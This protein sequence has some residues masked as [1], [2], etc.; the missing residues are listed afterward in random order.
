MAVHRARTAASVATLFLLASLSVSTSARAVDCAS[1]D[2]TDSDPCT[3]DGCDPD[4]GCT[5]TTP[6]QCHGDRCLPGSCNEITGQCPATTNIC[7]SAGVCSTA[8][9][10]GPG[11]SPPCTDT[12]VDCA[13][14]NQCISQNCDTVTGCTGTPIN[15]DDRNVCSDDSCNP[16]TGCVHTPLSCDDG[17]P[18]TT[19]SCDAAA[20]CQHTRFCGSCPASPR[21]DCKATPTGGSTLALA[22]SSENTLGWSWKKG[23]A[24]SF[25]DLGDPTTATAY[26]VCLYDG[27][28]HLLDEYAIP[29]GGDCSGKPCWKFSGSGYQY[30]DKLGSSNGI[31]KLSIKAGVSGKST[32]KLAGKGAGLT[33]PGLPLTQSPGPATI[34]LLN[35]SATACWSA[36]FSDPPADSTGTEWKDTSD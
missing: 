14:G 6:D 2:C 3:V 7:N 29:A 13:H 31:V 12:P 8:K 32:L 5:H 27:G 28:N 36:A 9:C 33:V 22:T 35:S 17:D 30:S 18:C 23:D 11:G 26:R 21:N 19:D 1:L 20:G 24:T 34:Q 15:C 16:S 4:Y 25:A 10:T